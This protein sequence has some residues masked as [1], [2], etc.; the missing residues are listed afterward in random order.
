MAVDQRDP[1]LGS[2][3]AAGLLLL[4]S[5]GILYYISK[6]PLE[7]GDFVLNVFGT[8]AIAGCGIWGIAIAVGI[9]CYGLYISRRKATE[10]DP[11]KGN[12]PA[13]P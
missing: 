12:P 7:A 10:T 5:V 13:V 8:L 1:G 11:G 4:A 9:Y 3:K 6:V 2:R